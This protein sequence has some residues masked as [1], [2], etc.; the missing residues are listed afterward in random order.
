MLAARHPGTTIRVVN[1][2]VS[3][4]NSA[5]VANRLERNIATYDPTL[6]IVWVGLN[7]IWN[8]TETEVW[9]GGSFGVAVRRALLH[10]RLY[11]LATVV[12][13][14]KALEADSG[15]TQMRQAG[16]RTGSVAPEDVR[17]GLRFDLER[18]ARMAFARRIPVIVMQYPLPYAVVNRTIWSTAFRLG[19]PL[20]QTSLDLRRAS[21]DGHEKA[22]LLS[23]GAGPHP[24]GLLYK[25]IAESTL[26]QVEKDLRAKG[27]PL[28]PGS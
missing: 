17:R 9:P 24:T 27:V 5:W 13:H 19:I 10:S 6:I 20:V 12:W 16:M 4:A 15:W 23:F 11:R 22:A 1:R 18:M 7:D 21:A 28:A 2:G 25:Y 8:L 26:P 3:G 14:T